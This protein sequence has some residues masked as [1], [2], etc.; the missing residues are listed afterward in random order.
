[1]FNLSEGIEE[2]VLKK[3][4]WNCIITKCIFLRKKSV[5]SLL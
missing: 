5:K 2:K 4:K 3:E 1:M